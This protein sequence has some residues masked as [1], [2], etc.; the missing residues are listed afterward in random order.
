M[1]LKLDGVDFLPYLEY[2]GLKWKKKD[3]DINNALQTMNGETIRGEV[4]Y[5]ST[6]DV[7]CRPLTT[8]EAN[9]VLNVIKPAYITV[10]YNDPMDGFSIKTMFC[11]ECP[12]AFMHQKKDGTELWKGIAFQLIER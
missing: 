7:S 10:E 6:L 11:Q 9:I 3:I 12:A 2:R 1:V 4:V 5:K 8:D